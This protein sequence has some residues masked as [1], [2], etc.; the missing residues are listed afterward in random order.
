MLVENKIPNSSPETEPKHIDPV[1]GMTVDPADAAG[2][3]EYKGTTYYFC[4]SSCVTKFKADP[5]KYLEPKTSVVSPA[6]PANVEYTCPMDPEVRQVGPGSC[7]KCG[8]A[9]EP[10]T[11]APPASKTEWTCPMHPEIVRAEPGSC[12]I[13]GMALEPR[14]VTMED[15]NPELRSMTR[16]FWS[17]VALTSPILALMVSE[18]LPGKPLQSWLGPQAVLWVQFLLA[19]PV[20]LWGGWPF[21]VRGWQSIVNRHPNMFTLVALGTGAAYVYSVVATLFPGAFPESFRDPHTGAL[22]LY[23]EPAAVIVALVLLGQ[24]LE[25]RARSQTSS[26]FGHSLASLR[27]VHG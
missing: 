16:R 27:E 21:F 12:P 1:C 18:M 19:T 11:I 6:G 5:K 14:T 15:D 17:S 26:A 4:S 3:H 22:A 23:F 24:V 9:L 25:L 20:V 8:M 13:C 2:S 7:P 10:V